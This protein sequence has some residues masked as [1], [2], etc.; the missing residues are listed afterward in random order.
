[1]TPAEAVGIILIVV[2]LIRVAL[3]IRGPRRE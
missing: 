3:A 1:V 2:T